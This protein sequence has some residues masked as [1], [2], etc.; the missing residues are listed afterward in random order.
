MP[1]ALT[2]NVFYNNKEEAAEL[3]KPEVSQKIAVAHVEAILE[4]E[5]SGL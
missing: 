5:K 2:E 1:A 3:M 4:I